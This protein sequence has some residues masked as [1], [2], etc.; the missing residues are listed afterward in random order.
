M[1]GRLQTGPVLRKPAHSSGVIGQRD[2]KTTM[3][4]TICSTDR[5]LILFV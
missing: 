5:R 3:I 2:L 1:G 4:Y